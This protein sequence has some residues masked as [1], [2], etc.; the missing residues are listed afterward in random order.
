MKRRLSSWPQGELHRQIEYK[1]LAVGVP[2]I[3]VDPRGTSKTCPT[4][5]APKGRRERVGQVFTCAKCGWSMDRQHNAGLNIL[6]IAL[7]S[8]EALARAVRFWP[9]ALRDDVVSPLYDLPAREG[10]REESSGVELR[11]RALIHHPQM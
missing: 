2:V 5:D 6:K 10:A 3:K 8:N 1:A 7:V 9:S 4:C 11:A